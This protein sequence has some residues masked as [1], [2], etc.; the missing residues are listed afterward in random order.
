MLCKSQ[1]NWFVVE[2]ATVE[3]NDLSSAKNFGFEVRLSN[4]K[5]KQIKR[6]DDRY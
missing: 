6:R 1:L 3:N 2:F 5:L 4:R